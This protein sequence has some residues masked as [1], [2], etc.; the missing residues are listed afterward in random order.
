MTD[1]NSDN[2]VE[3]KETA[4]AIEEAGSSADNGDAHNA[5]GSSDAADRRSADS[6]TAGGD[7]ETETAE[8]KDEGSGDETDGSDT[9]TNTDNGSGSKKPRG[10][11]GRGKKKG[12]EFK[13]ENPEAVEAAMKR[14][15]DGMNS[16]N[17]TPQMERIA[18][19]QEDETRRVEKA[20]ENTKSN[21]AW[22]VPIFSIHLILGLLWVVVFYLTHQYPIPAIGNWN[23]AV[24][25]GISFIGFILL[26]WWE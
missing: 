25:A 6:D 14:L 5:D 1:A 23:L 20:I 18:K 9:G 8:D 4:E 10:L 16:D 13:P 22:L 2:I 26:M 12:Y 7:A 24:G 3:D 21:P 15:E 17:M 11:F 19:R